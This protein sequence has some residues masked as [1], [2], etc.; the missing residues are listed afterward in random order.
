MASLN[1]SKGFENHKASAK[2]EN[3]GQEKRMN[4]LLKT[5][6]RAMLIGAIVLLMSIG[7]NI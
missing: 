6:S 4:L 2:I 3:M 5:M 7:F 1:L